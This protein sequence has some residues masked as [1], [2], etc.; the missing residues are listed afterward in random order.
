[1]D[2]K[3]GD[4]LPSIYLYDSNRVK[5]N[6][7]DMVTQK[8]VIAFLPGA[9]TEVCTTE[10]CTFE[11]YVADLKRLNATIIG[12]TTDSPYVL[13]E[14]GSLNHVTFPLLSDFDKECIKT[15]STEFH[16]LGGMEGYICSNRSI[17]IVDD[18]KNI[19]H[20]WHASNPGV[21]PEYEK[22][23]DLLR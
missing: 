4:A 23:I 14:W 10:I 22:I 16:N 19:I 9:Y 17:F 18:K 8:T 5:R 15:F 6:L 7:R 20:I 13:N 1:M 12:I 11:S 21:Q 2:L 3:V